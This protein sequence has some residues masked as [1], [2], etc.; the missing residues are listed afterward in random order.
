MVELPRFRSM[1]SDSRTP[2]FIAVMVLLLSAAANLPWQLDDYDQ[3]KQAFTSFQM[4]N[5]GHWLY[6][7]TP[8]DWVATKPPLVG[9]ISAALFVITRCWDLAWRLPSFIAAVAIA[10]LL[11][12]VSRAAYG[13]LPAIVA[14]AAFGLNLLSPRLATLAR[15]DMPLALITFATGALIWS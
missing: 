5:E 12:R 8:H 13:H 4:L 11:F 6:Q 1:L 14:I 15:T 10:A 7:T 3:A 9:W 2:W